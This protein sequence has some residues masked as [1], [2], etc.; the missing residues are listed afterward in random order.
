MKQNGIQLEFIVCFFN[1]TKLTIF[2]YFIFL[3]TFH[4][5]MFYRAG[6]LFNTAMMIMPLKEQ[7]FTN[8]KI[9]DIHNFIKNL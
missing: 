6:R 5:S 4:F 1:E 2:F 7:H 3:P 8:M 9:K